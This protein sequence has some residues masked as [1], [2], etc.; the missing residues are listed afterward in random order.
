LPRSDNDRVKSLEKGLRL[1][2]LLADQKSAVSLEAITSLS[3]LNKTTCFRLLKTMQDMGF[4]EQEPGSKRYLLGPRNIA[5]GAV[6]MNRL[7]LRHM[8]LPVMKRLKDSLGETINF[9]VLIG[10]EIMFIERLEAE[11]IVSAHHDIGDRLPV[12]CTCMG[13]AILAHL[14]QDRLDLLIDQ[15][16]F[17]PKTANT[18]TSRQ[19]LLDELQRIRS[20]GLSYNLEELEKGLCA[21]AAPILDYSGHAVAALNVSFP[22]MRHDKKEALKKFA[23]QIKKAGIELSG[24]LGFIPSPEA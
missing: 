19:A 1:L 23:P 14:P 3:G 24:M 17:S 8:A 22:L 21:V 18:I 15:I 12:H 2:I 11:H 10:T 6:A 7:H 16:Q 20:E 4:V 5:L 9:S 13:K